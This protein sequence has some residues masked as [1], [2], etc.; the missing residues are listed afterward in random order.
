MPPLLITRVLLTVIL[1]AGCAHL[2]GF[3]FVGEPAPGQL[4]LR[5]EQAHPGTWVV[6]A[7]AGTPLPPPLVDGQ[8]I[9]V[10]RMSISD[11]AVLFDSLPTPAG[12]PITLVLPRK[13]G[14]LRAAVVA[15]PQQES[16]TRMS[17]VERVGA[18]VVAVSLLL[19]ALL[20]LW[21]GRDWTARGLCL[22]SSAILFSNLVQESVP[23]GSARLWLA[24]VPTL[25]QV[26][27]MV[28]LYAT[29]EGLAG[30]GL[31]QARRWL[32]R[33][34]VAAT[35]LT[36]L[37]STILPAAA[38][39]YVGV[40]LPGQLAGVAEASFAMVV[41]IPVLV[42]L[43][44]YRHASQESRRRMRWTFVSMAT[45]V[46]S[47]LIALLL[48]PAASAHPVAFMMFNM[49]VPAIAFLV[50]LYAILRTRLVD[51]RFV[52]DRALV[53]SVT[54]A[55]MF[56]LFS[57]L[58]Q[59][60]HRL[61]LGEQL[62]WVVQSLGA[63]A[64]AA[65]LSPLHRLLD[66]GLERVFFHRLRVM[67][68]ALRRLGMESAFFE[69]EDALLSRALKQLLAPCAAVAIYERHGALYQRRVAQGEGW[70]EAVDKDD[71]L[72][73][74][75]RARHEVLDLKGQESA[76]GDE[77]LA[78]PMSVGQLLTGAVVCRLREGEQLD[79][80]VRSAISELAHALGTSLY[81]LRYQEQ[82]RL[83]AE[84]AAGGVDPGSVRTRIQAVLGAAERPARTLS[85]SEQLTAQQGS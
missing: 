48:S 20:T 84:I 28:G 34:A 38:L 46:I 54:T 77:G 21:R 11:R 61:A 27:A 9:D 71:P 33:A 26:L 23:P 82:S 83:L 50:L 6:R 80:D 40:V 36:A 25:L 58:E 57:L 78:V 39:V 12:R 31:S 32:S 43:T 4:P 24:H 69:S 62:G 59:A 67:A 10:R 13:G 16:L 29:A 42:L 35:G 53:F 22:F 44:G 70:P 74:A 85:R 56:G 7:R 81:L 5:V 3:R 76:A 8:V 60:V 37:A 68:G 19:M 30:E 55:L 1:L 41:V 64:I 79:R 47:L 66:R 49:M 15:R 75:L 63:V 45:L 72:F 17:S 18:G 51:V 73:V 52:I 14:E 65:V 2:V